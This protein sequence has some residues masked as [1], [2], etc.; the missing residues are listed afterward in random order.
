MHARKKKETMSEDTSD[1]LTNEERASTWLHANWPS[2]QIWS[3]DV[4]ASL[5]ALLVGDRVDEV[6]RQERDELRAL[7]AIAIK[8]KWYMIEQDRDWSADAVETELADTV[9]NYEN[10]HPDRALGFKMFL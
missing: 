2:H 7:A 10:A 6:M 3:V 5:T 8:W 1:G 9:T 4:A